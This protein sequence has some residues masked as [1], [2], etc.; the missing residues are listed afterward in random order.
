MRYKKMM[1]HLY[2]AKDRN[3][4]YHSVLDDEKGEVQTIKCLFCGYTQENVILERRVTVAKNIYDGY[5]KYA[6]Q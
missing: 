1:Y 2:C 6:E 3:Y 4:T 5:E